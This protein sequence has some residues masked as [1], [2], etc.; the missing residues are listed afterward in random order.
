[1]PYAPTDG[2]LR[3]GADVEHPGLLAT[4][5]LLVLFAPDTGGPPPISDSGTVFFS[6][7]STSGIEA[8]ADAATGTI[9]VAATGTEAL[10]DTAGGSIEVLSAGVEALADAGDSAVVLSPAGLEAFA[11]AG[12]QLITLQPTGVLGLV[13]RL[14]VLRIDLDDH[15][16]LRIDLGD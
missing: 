8:L 10:A 15:A 2:F 7:A 5:G 6:L 3:P 14:L 1:M 13:R 12:L 4:D 16:A 9:A 11:D